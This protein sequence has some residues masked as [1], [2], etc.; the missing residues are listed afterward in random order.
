MAFFYFIEISKFSTERNIKRSCLASPF[1]TEP[2]T[3]QPR[4]LYELLN[5]F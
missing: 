5:G 4:H 3:N 2:K 1:L